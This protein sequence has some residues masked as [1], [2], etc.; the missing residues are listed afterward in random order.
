MN[1]IEIKARA[2]SAVNANLGTCLVAYLVY[3]LVGSMISSTGI[4]SF[5]IGFL[6]LALAGGILKIL[7]NGSASFEDFINTLTENAGTKFIGTLLVMLYTWLWSLLFVIPGIIKGY[8]YA[9]TGYILIDRPE[10]TAT[11][12]IDESKKMMDGHK[13]EL[14][15]LDLSFIGWYLLGTLTCGLLFFWI[16]PY[17]MTA[18]AAFY[19]ELK[20]PDEIVIED[21]E[22]VIPQ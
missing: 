12:S 2:K 15:I 17:Q 9:M 10:L 8:S 21:P 20:G 6:A 16:S 4:G 7:R 19:E 5:A 1:R 22:I 14:F 3:M 13:M 18:R 11:Q